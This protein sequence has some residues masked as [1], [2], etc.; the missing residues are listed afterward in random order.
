MDGWRWEGK[1]EEGRR[2]EKGGKEESRVLIVGFFVI[3]K[4]CGGE[5]RG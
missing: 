1:G 3:W 4:R 2:N 5:A